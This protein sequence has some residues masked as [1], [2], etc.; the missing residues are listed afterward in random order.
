MPHGRIGKRSGELGIKIK[1]LPA[2]VGGRHILEK[3]TVRATDEI[4]H[5]RFRYLQLEKEMEHDG[6]EGK[7]KVAKK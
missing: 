2:F 3:L 4:E 6:G 5:P 7:L 1:V